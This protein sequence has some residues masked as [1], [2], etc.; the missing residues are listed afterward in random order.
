MNATDLKTLTTYFLQ[1]LGNKYGNDGCNDLDM[2]SLIP[3]L[4]TR[5]ALVIEFSRLNNDNPQDHAWAIEESKRT[6]DQ[7]KGPDYRLMNFSLLFV[8]QKRLID[9]LASPSKSRLDP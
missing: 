4:D 5:N 6:P 2:K 9:M 1:Q 8:L 3:D 7:D